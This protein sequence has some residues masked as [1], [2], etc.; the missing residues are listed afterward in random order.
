MPVIVPESNQDTSFF[1][2]L[3]DCGAVV[4]DEQAASHQD[5]RP[6]RIGLLNLMPAPV[7]EATEL[8]WLRFISQTVLQVEPVLIKFDNDC[9]E[10]AG[11]R[12]KAILERYKPFSEVAEQGLDG[13]IIT[14]DNQELRRD[15]TPRP[16]SELH[17]AKDLSSVTDWADEQVGASIYS[18]LA[19]HFALNRRYGLE[20]KIGSK[21]VYGVFEHTV[22]T[23]SPATASMDDV[24]RAPHSRWGDISSDQL[25]A[26]GISILAQ[27]DQIGWLIAEDANSKGSINLYLQGHPEYWRFDL[28]HE[29][30]RD[31]QTIP[32]NYY[33]EDDPT[34]KPVLSWSSDARSLLSNWIHTIYRSYSL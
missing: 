14:G 22:T 11:S 30:L 19:S 26:N 9:R 33:P 7:M 23:E 1:E 27:N 25:T 4:I 18:C 8:R 17:Y 32:A 12:R 16:L 13:L 3:R 2:R 34:N 29:Y 15:G 20:R 21:K 5:I 10:R 6:A 24:I 31:H 28:H